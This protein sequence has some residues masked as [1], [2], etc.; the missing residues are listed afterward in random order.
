MNKILSLALIFVLIIACEPDKTQLTGE[1]S[2]LD[3]GTEIY[4][5][6]LEN[7]QNVTPI[8]TLIVENNTFVGTLESAKPQDVYI[9]MVDGVSGQNLVFINENKDLNIKLSEENLRNSEVISGENNQLLKE[10]LADQ[11]SISEESK[12]KQNEM[13]KAMYAGDRTKFQNLKKELSEIQEANI[14]RKKEIA[15]NN[16][17]SVVSLL[18]INDFVKR[19]SIPSSESKALFKNLSADLK[20][21]KSGKTLNKSI[22]A[23]NATDIGSVAPKF[24]APTPNG[25]MLSLDDALG[26]VTLVDFWASWCKPCRMEN[27]NIVSVYQDYKDKGFTVLG[28]SLDKPNQKNRWLK[29][30]EDDNLTWNHVSNLQYWSDPV[31]RM[32][33]INSIPAAFLLD[34]NGKIIAKD[35]RGNAL[36]AKVS[37]LLDEESTVK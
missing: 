21:S 18:I 25:D 1:A 10:Y 28:V 5:S 2:F 17:N 19:K 32:Y 11:V 26:K 36:R 8:D 33:G 29:A 6:Q 9:L 14:S 30:I 23:V 37:E 3:N 22:I 35:L 13:R 20:D 15:Q 31:A 27:P 16:T 34:E 7:L 24:E 12:A 4:I